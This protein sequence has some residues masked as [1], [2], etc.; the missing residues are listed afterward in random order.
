MIL[1]LFFCILRHSLTDLS[2]SSAP[3][4]YFVL[5]YLGNEIEPNLES[6]PKDNDPNELF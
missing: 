3:I 2:N 1:K 5:L 6:V 4:R